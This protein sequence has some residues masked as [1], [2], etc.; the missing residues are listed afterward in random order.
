MEIRCVGPHTP[1]SRCDFTPNTYFLYLCLCDSPA[2]WTDDDFTPWHWE[3]YTVYLS[4]FA[5]KLSRS[6]EQS[7][8]TWRHTTAWW[9][10]FKHEELLLAEQAGLMIIYGQFSLKLEHSVTFSHCFSFLW[11]PFQTFWNHS[12]LVCLRL[13]AVNISDPPLMCYLILFNIKFS[14]LF[15]QPYGV[16]TRHRGSTSTSLLL[17]LWPRMTS[18]LVHCVYL[19]S[20]SIDCIR[21]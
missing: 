4:R 3:E 17:R 19:T 20:P 9:P 1:Q 11:S 10:D 7:R 14:Q 15:K 21:S 2:R 6:S 8:D 18:C 13:A 12:D 16:R 5:S